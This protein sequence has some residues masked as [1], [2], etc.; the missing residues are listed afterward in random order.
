MM[1]IHKKALQEAER[2]ITVDVDSMKMMSM[3]KKLMTAGVRHADH[4][5]Q[6]K[7]VELAS[8]YSALSLKWDKLEARLQ[9]VDA[10]TKLEPKAEEPR[11][12]PS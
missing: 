1:M 6:N 3:K 2:K 4:L 7:E 12:N 5:Q 9:T 11:R 10:N 8:C